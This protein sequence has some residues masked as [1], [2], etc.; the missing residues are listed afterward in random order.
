METLKLKTTIKCNGCVNTVKPFLEDSN[1][2]SNWSVDLENPE[3]I[4]TV[5]TEGNE[6]EVVDLLHKAGYK[7]EKV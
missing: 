1:N 7:A 2:I 4:L 5:A 3:K 6:N